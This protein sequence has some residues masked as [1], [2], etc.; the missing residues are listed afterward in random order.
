MYTRVNSFLEWILDTVYENQDYLFGIIPRNEKNDAIRFP[1][2]RRKGRRRREIKQ[3]K[4]KKLRK[5]EKQ[6]MSRRYRQ[7]GSKRR[8]FI[9]TEI[10]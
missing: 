5:L 4:L 9:E 7:P 8:K 1:T 2:G 6:R 10:V 3:K